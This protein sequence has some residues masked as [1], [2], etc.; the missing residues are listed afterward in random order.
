MDVPGEFVAYTPPPSVRYEVA[1]VAIRCAWFWEGD[2]YAW[3]RGRWEAPRPGY[4]WVAHEW[5][6]VGSTWH[7]T[8]GHWAR[9]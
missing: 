8:A 4:H 9:G 7:M 6:P 2:R 3:H 5:R 1:R